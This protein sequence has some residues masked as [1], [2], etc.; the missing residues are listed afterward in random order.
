MPAELADERDRLRQRAKKQLDRAVATLE[1]A[2]RDLKPLGRRSVQ[3]L[4]DEALDLG[5]RNRLPADSDDR[6]ATFGG[7]GEVAEVRGSQIAVV[8][9]NKRLWVPAAGVEVVRQPGKA[10]SKRTVH[11]DITDDAPRE[12]MLLGLDSERARDEVEKAL[13]QAF[14]AGQRSIRIVHGHGTGTLRRMVAE[15]CREHPAVRSFA[16]PPG[17]RGGTGATEVELEESG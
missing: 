4:R 3:K 5:D 10:R 11:V 14:A 9:G 6:L 1:E 2:T 17:N 16:H 13:D 12:L 7:E 8:S 15:V